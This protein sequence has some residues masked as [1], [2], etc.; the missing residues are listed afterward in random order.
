MFAVLRGGLGHAIRSKVGI[1]VIGAML[2]A[3]GGT[4]LAL[5]TSHARFP[6]GARAA[7]PPGHATA[8]ASGSRHATA[9]GSPTSVA[10][11]GRGHHGHHHAHL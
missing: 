9:S 6:P 7:I 8:T 5:T 1:A 4:A 10:G 3:G 2:I 11:G